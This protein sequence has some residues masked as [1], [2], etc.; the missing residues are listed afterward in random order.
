MSHEALTWLRD[1]FRVDVDDIDLDPADQS[2]LLWKDEDILFYIDE[3][4][5]Q[6]VH[7]TLYRH[8]LLQVF[9][10]AELSSV[11]LPER[12]IELRGSVAY[13]ESSGTPVHEINS[14]EMGVA[15]DDYGTDIAIDPYVEQTPGRPRNFSLDIDAGQVHLFPPSSVEDMLKIP[16]YLEARE[17]TDWNCTLDIKNKR[18]QRMLL[19]GIKALAYAKQDADA[20]DP[21]Q[22]A[23]W[24]EAFQRDI[25][26]V[27]SERLRRRRKPGQ[28]QYGGL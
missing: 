27:N 18:H 12:V 10:P 26:Q 8:E 21:N 24:Q 20:Y 9:I 15:S 23:R 2:G 16:A 1:R 17:I 22:A 5:S 11:A 3:A 6:F 25:D 19:N 4:H 7:D 13:L 28:V 14:D